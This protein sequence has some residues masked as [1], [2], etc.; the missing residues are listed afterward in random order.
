M[1]VPFVSSRSLGRP[2]NGGYARYCSRPEKSPNRNGDQGVVERLSVGP[3]HRV[4][5]RFCAA[6]EEGVLTVEE[7]KAVLRGLPAGRRTKA[8]GKS[9]SGRRGDP[10]RAGRGLSTR[11]LSMK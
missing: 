4:Q 11:M 6:P 7:R 1:R 9:T 5:V 8:S 2:A 3:D 10:E